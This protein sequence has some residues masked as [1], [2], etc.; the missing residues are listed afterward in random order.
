MNVLLFGFKASGKT[1]LGKLLSK[2]L[3]RPFIDTDDLIMQLYLEEFGKAL[4]VREIHQTLSEAGFRI[5]EKTAIHKLKSNSNAI[6]ALGGGAIL[7]PDNLSYLQTIGKLIYLR[8]SFYTVQ[9][10]ILSGTIPSFIDSANPKEAL[11]K[12]YQNRLPVY[13]SIPAKCVNVDLMDEAGCIAALC[14]IVLSEDKS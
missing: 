11:N 1:H 12:I 6:I 2:E 13:E 14:S 4:S 8:A 7:D 3:K 5:L 9:K 10:R